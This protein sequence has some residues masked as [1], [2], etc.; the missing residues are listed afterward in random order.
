MTRRAA[1]P[2]VHWQT[3]VPL[4]RKVIVS[5]AC[6]KGK[7]SVCYVLDCKCSCGHHVCETERVNKR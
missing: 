5:A 2:R 1:P 3:F 6:K 7:H 4:H